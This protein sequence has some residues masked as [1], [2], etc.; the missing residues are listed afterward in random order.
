MEFPSSAA[1]VL[2]WFCSCSTHTDMLCCSFSSKRVKKRNVFFTLPSSMRRSRYL[3]TCRAFY[4]HYTT[5]IHATHLN[6]LFS[7]T[8]GYNEMEQSW[9]W[10]VI[11]RPKHSLVMRGVPPVVVTLTVWPLVFLAAALTQGDNI[12]TTQWVCVQYTFKNNCA[13]PVVVCVCDSGC[14]C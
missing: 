11:G 10:H 14:E 3:F 1:H 5:L 9:C 6:V 4:L 7:S 12:T 8:I 13:Q 2:N